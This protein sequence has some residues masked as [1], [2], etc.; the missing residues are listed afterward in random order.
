MFLNVFLTLGIT[1]NR[2]MSSLSFPFEHNTDTQIVW[3]WRSRNILIADTGF[4][5]TLWILYWD[6][7]IQDIKKVGK[8]LKRLIKVYSNLLNFLSFERLVCA[9]DLPL[10]SFSFHYYCVHKRQHRYCLYYSAQEEYAELFVFDKN[11]RNNNPLRV[12]I[13]Y[14]ITTD[15]N[16]WMATCYF[17]PGPFWS[18]QGIPFYIKHGHSCELHYIRHITQM[19]AMHFLIS[20]WNLTQWT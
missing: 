8:N 4:Y 11:S 7:L 18:T 10:E 9:E 3:K 14:V 5:A 15:I 19:Y 20:V 16:Q 1:K 12:L 2:K 6:C 17:Q 13:S